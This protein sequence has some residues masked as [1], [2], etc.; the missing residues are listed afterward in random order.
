[1]KNILAFGDSLTWGVVA[2]KDARHSFEDRWPNA[3]A[4]G[5]DGK[6][7][8]VEEGQ[9]GRTTFRVIWFPPGPVAFSAAGPALK[10]TRAAAAKESVS[11]APIS[12][13]GIDPLAVGTS[14]LLMAAIAIPTTFLVLWPRGVAI[15]T[16]CWS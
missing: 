16:R 14:A 15:D 6:A 2:G 9:N 8:V 3:L 4:A 12:I 10:A 13:T 11:G 1:M 7:Y 5:L